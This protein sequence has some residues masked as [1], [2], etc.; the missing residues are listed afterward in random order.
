MSCRPV[1]GVD[2]GRRPGE[3]ELRMA[4]KVPVNPVKFSSH[5]HK[6]WLLFLIHSCLLDVIVAN[7]DLSMP[8]LPA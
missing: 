1:V 8:F 4:W 2:T 6:L 5:P 3:I 7:S